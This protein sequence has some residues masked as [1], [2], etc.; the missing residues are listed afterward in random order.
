MIKTMKYNDL[1]I[2]GQFHAIFENYI[3]M[4]MHLYRKIPVW[5][6]NDTRKNYT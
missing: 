3:P 1:N 4:W 6:D 2:Y 5:E